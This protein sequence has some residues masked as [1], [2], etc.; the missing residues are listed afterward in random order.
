[1]LSPTDLRSTDE[2]RRQ[3]SLRALAFLLAMNELQL[4]FRVAIR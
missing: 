2:Y 4:Q 1:M 3:S